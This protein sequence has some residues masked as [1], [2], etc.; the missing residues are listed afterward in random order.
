MILL[1]FFFCMHSDGIDGVFF[2]LSQET[3]MMAIW[4][5]CRGDVR[6]N[7][8]VGGLGDLRRVYE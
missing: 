1:C 8:L 6:I 3:F 5:I 7:Y 4:R 2:C